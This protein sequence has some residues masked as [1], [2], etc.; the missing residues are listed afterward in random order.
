MLK[1]FLLFNLYTL[2]R[3]LLIADFAVFG[4]PFGFPSST[5][6][7][8]LTFETLRENGEVSLSC[9]PQG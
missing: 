2:S 4:V 1:L 9:S 5:G 6:G 7:P 3:V 8:A